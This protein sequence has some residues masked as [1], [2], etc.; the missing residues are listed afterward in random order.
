MSVPSAIATQDLLDGILKISSEAII[1]TDERGVVLMFS[2]GAETIFGYRAAEMIGASIERLI[3]PE[4]RAH[5]RDHVAAFGK[6]PVDTVVMRERGTIQ[7]LRKD[8]A[9]FALEASLSRSMTREGMVFTTLIRDVSA[10][11]A[12]QAAVAASE[13]RLRIALQ[14]ARMHVIEIDYQAQ[15]LSKAGAEEIFF[16]RPLTFAALEADIWAGLRPDHRA[17]AD[18][19]WREHLGSGQPFRFEAPT[20]RADGKC[21]WALVTGEL[22]MDE[23][24]RRL[25]LVGALQDITARRLAQEAVSTAAAA[26]QAANRAKSEFLATMSHEIRTPLNGVLGMAQAMELDPLPPVQRDRLSVIRES[27]QALLAILDDVL[28]LSKIEA[29]KLELEEAEFELAEVARRAQAAFAALAAKKGVRLTL[30]VR[31]AQGAYVGDP[32]RVLQILYNLI[33]NGLKFTEAGEVQVTARHRHGALV[34]A[35]SDTGIGMTPAV[36]ETLFTPFVQ[37]DTSTTRRFGGTGLG[38]SITRSLVE[39]MSGSIQVES[40][41]GRG[42]RFVVT[43]PLPRAEPSRERTDRP[44]LAPASTARSLASLRVLAAEDNPTNQLVIKTLLSQIGIEPVFVDN[45][46]DAVSAWEEGAFDMILMDVRMPELDGPDATL[47]IR[48]REAVLGRPR[49][50]IIGLTANAMP[51]QILSYQQAGMDTVVTKPIDVA[52]LFEALA[53]FT[54]AG[55]S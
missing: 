23:Q 35:V 7:G 50:P 32:I 27:G 29:G 4:A 11:E 14:N 53:V 51:D 38:L 2:V 31:Q 42:S 37:A 46:R 49:T 9:R 12:G 3:P 18:A 36:V 6:G 16:D 30:D 41:P 1:V 21:V 33:S 28:D 10:R 40:T 54:Q 19:A 26:A 22:V 55:D 20:N 13:R 17:A 39:K 45:G 24:G 34:L 25:R 47:A 48:A 43:L 52:S 8:G 44:R 15:V 5:H